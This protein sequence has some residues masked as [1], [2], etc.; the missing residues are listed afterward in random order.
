MRFVL[1]VK[2]MVIVVGYGGE[3]H[4]DGGDDDH[5]GHMVMRHVS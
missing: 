2:R 1:I 3:L 5:D 4:A